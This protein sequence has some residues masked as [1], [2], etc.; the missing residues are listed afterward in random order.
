MGDKTNR[1]NCETTVIQHN[2][3]QGIDLFGKLKSWFK[4]IMDVGF[5]ARLSVLR[6]GNQYQY[7]NHIVRPTIAGARISPEAD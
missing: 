3:G 7:C 2:D 5:N 4:P 6:N 1:I